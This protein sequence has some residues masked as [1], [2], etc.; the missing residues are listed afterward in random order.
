MP[1]AAIC[2]FLG[3]CGAMRP[4]SY[5]KTMTLWILISAGSLGHSA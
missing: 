4:H 2:T 1:A 3:M 5:S